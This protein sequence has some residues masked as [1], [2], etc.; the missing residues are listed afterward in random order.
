MSSDRSVSQSVLPLM[1]LRL[2]QR[3][4]ILLDAASSDWM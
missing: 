3:G 1:Q 4:D 2:K